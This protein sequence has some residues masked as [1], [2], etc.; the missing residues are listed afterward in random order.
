MIGLDVSLFLTIITCDVFI[1]GAPIN[2]VYFF[3]ST[4]IHKQPDIRTPLLNVGHLTVKTQYSLQVTLDILKD[5]P[6]STINHQI[7]K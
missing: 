4:S 1:L 3:G 6:L 7:P 2:R 5:N